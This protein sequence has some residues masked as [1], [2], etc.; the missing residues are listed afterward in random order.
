L[1]I[2][3]FLV[4]Y[5]ILTMLVIEQGRTIESQR[6]LLREMLKDSNQLAELKTKLASDEAAPKQAP[7]R[8][9]AQPEQKDPLAKAPAANEKDAKRSGKTA[10]SMK[11]VPGK[12][13]ADLEDVRRSTNVL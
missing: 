8:A 5:S 6:I 13:A 3:L 4:S 10:R 1:L 12:P 7:A 11:S 2:L 9:Q